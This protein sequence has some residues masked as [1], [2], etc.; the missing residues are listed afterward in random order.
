ML[1]DDLD[2][3]KRFAGNEVF[4]DRSKGAS[5]IH[6]NMNSNIRFRDYQHEALGRFLV[7]MDPSTYKARQRPTRL[8]FNMATG[9]GKTVIMS[10]SILHLYKLG[11]RNFVFFT[12]LGQIVDKTRTNFLD[13]KSIKYLYSDEIEID[14]KRVQIREVSNFSNRNSSDIQIMFTTTTNLHFQLSNPKESS[15]SWIEFEGQKTVLIADEAH[16]LSSGT[17]K[18][19]TKEELLVES[20]WEGTVEKLLNL[21]PENNILLEFTATARLDESNPEVIEKYEDSLLVKYDLKR[22]REDGYSKDVITF[23]F[24]A[25]LFE[26]VL[27]ALVTSQYRLKVAEKHKLSIKPVVLLKSNRTSMSD[28]PG[29]EPLGET[30]VVSSEFKKAFF[31]FLNSL[32]ATQIRSLTT[33]QDPLLIRAFEF[34]KAQGVTFES[35]AVEIRHSFSEPFSFSVDEPHPQGV[36]MNILNSL[37]S[38]ENKVRV[39]FATEKLNEGWDVLNLFDIVRLYNAR[40]AKANKAGKTTIQEAQLIGRGARYYPFKLDSVDSREQRKFDLDISNELRVL[41]ELHY[42]SQSNPRYIQELRATLIETGLIAETNVIRRINVKKEIFESEF[43]SLG[44]ILTNSRIDVLQDLDHSNRKHHLI[45]NHHDESNVY[46]LKTM[47][48]R[49]GAIFEGESKKSSGLTE[50][51]LL[52]FIDIPSNISRHALISHR[53]GDLINLKRQFTNLSTIGEFLTSDD[54]LGGLQVQI[55]GLP[56]QI[57]NLNQ[58]DLLNVA[59]HLIGTILQFEPG[60]SSKHIGSEEFT[61]KP[62]AEVFNAPKDLKLDS[63]RDRERTT[64]VQDVI[65]ESAS[66]FAQNE[67]WGTSE[68]KALVRFLSTKLTFLENLFD[69][70]LLVR[71]EMHFPIYSFDE[72]R[73][74]YPDFV[75]FLQPK[76]AEPGEML[77]IFIEPKGDQ[78]LDLDSTFVRSQEGWKQAFLEEIEERGVPVKEFAGYRLFG[79]PFFNSGKVNSALLSEFADKFSSVVNSGE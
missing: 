9:S 32:D 29:F 42:H 70:V 36:E 62:L 73:A 71:N 33:V 57:S 11:Y 5:H 76:S 13:Q 1:K 6:E 19:L 72:G 48:V 16:N 43:W 58:T 69:K 2:A 12:R 66:W 26:R 68:E 10:A 38:P 54:Y 74:F 77:Q 24:D 25:P 59:K 52:K 45:F 15:I 79:L 17:Q 63:V 7:Y 61:A 4:S 50:R 40:D 67:I 8:L 41:E 46:R 31:E 27:A 75:L 21:N 51:K 44:T 35:L 37:E 20:S 56:D 39:I 3:F 18:G 49:E 53:R 28:K 55:E 78:F 30:T 64:P 60:N 23:E 14:G 22:F 47:V 34:F 65:L